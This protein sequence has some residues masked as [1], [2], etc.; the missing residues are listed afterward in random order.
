[1]MILLHPNK[2]KSPCRIIWLLSS[3]HRWVH[4]SWSRCT[5]GSQMTPHLSGFF[6]L[7]Q[8]MTP[9][10]YRDCWGGPTNDTGP[11]RVWDRFLSLKT[12]RV[13]RSTL[14]SPRWMSGMSQIGN[15]PPPKKDSEKERWTGATEPGNHKDTEDTTMIVQIEEVIR[16]IRVLSFVTKW[17]PVDTLNSHGHGYQVSLRCSSSEEYGTCGMKQ[18]TNI[19]QK[20]HKIAQQPRKIRRHPPTRLLWRRRRKTILLKKKCKSVNGWW[21][22]RELEHMLPVSMMIRTVRNSH[23][24]TGTS[25]IIVVRLYIFKTVVLL[26][27]ILTQMFQLHRKVRRT[28]WIILTWDLWPGYHWL[29]EFGDTGNDTSCEKEFNLSHHTWEDYW[30][31][32]RVTRFYKRDCVLVIQRWLNR[33]E[34]D[35][36]GLTFQEWTPDVDT[37]RSPVTMMVNS[38]ELRGTDFKLKEVLPPHLS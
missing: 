27:S 16:A 32:Y 24:T 13:D 1:M 12:S 31:D 34:E 33:V 19:A 8:Q 37:S 26:C 22:Q 6:W 21:N 35:V 30:E 9:H 23:R 4:Q 10:R 3:F 20:P 28:R 38:S 17:S 11:D 18:E 25:L 36:S 14:F 2:K 7:V 29:C 5:G 15:F